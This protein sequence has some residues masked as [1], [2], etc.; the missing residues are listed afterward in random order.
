MKNKNGKKIALL[1]NNDDDVYCFRLELIQELVDSGYEMIISCPYGPKFE[2]L[3]DI[4][5]IHDDVQIDRRGTS[6]KNDFNLLCHYIS[7]FKKYKPDYALMYTIKP[8]IYASIAARITNTKY[9]NNITG[10]GSILKKGKIMQNFIYFLLRIALKKSK[11]VFFQ[12]ETNMNLILENKIVKENYKLIPGSGVN[13]ERFPAFE[14]PQNDDVIVFNYIGRV[15][16]EKGIDDYI[17]AA[18]IIKKKY[19]NTEFNII[20]FIE[21]TEIHYKDEFEKLEKDNI[22]IYRGQQQDVRPFI[23]KAHAIIHPSKYGEGMSNVLLENASSGRP[24]ITTNNPGC[25]ETVEDGKTGFIY[26]K[27][28]VSDLVN[29][30]EKFISL[31]NEEKKQ[32]GLL[33]REK[34]LKEFDRKIVIEAYKKIIER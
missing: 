10:L 3:K 5:Y 30:I 18:K 4:A 25:F 21:P 19:P 24:L 23:K 11:C 1:T 33:G 29:K 31:T 32:M 9:I 17:A 13:V 22:I 14:Y 6:I 34:M 26:E 27:G 28:N 20:G 8:N 16:S 15:L 2:L 7:F 12:N